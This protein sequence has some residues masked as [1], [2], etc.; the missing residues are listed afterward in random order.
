ME[1]VR[2]LDQVHETASARLGSQIAFMNELLT[3]ARQ[4]LDGGHTA[5]EDVDTPALTNGRGELEAQPYAQPKS[6]SQ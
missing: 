1:E 3:S 4:A 6:P 2:R 5:P